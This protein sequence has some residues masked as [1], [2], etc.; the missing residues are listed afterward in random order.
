MGVFPAK[1]K[2]ASNAPDYDC[3][4]PPATTTSEGTM[5]AADKT[6]LN[7]LSQNNLWSQF[8]APQLVTTND[9]NPLLAMSF[10][11]QS[12]DGVLVVTVDVVAADPT[13]AN[14]AFW[15]LLAFGVVRSNGVYSLG[16][17]GPQS[18]S[19]NNKGGAGGSWSIQVTVSGTTVQVTVA[20]TAIIGVKWSL[21]AAS[22]FNVTG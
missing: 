18:P 7:S 16:P 5:S 21:R 22:Q 9:A 12:Q 1:A 2:S 15:P 20:A 17:S 8:Y 6:A 19:T 11:A 3:M 14:F 10:P 4:V 13:A